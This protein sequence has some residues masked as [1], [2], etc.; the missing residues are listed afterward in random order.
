MTSGRARAVATALLA[1]AA[2]VSMLP[3]PAPAEAVVSDPRLFDGPSADLVGDPQSAMSEDGS[4]GIVYL[5][6][7]EGRAHVFAAKFEDGEWGPSQRVD[8]GQSFDSSWPRIAAGDNGRLLV[9][10]VQEFGID[11]D[12]MFSSTLDP[13]ASGFQSPVPVDFDVNEATSTFPDLA[14]ARGGQAYLIY[15]VITDVNTSNPP[16]YVGL[17]VRLARYSNRLWSAVGSR[18]DR[19]SSVPMRLPTAAIAPQVGIDIQGQAIVGWL[20]PDDDFVDRMWARRVFGGQTGIPVLVS[21]T[22]FNDKPLRGGVSA[23]SLDV[24]GFGQG[25]ASFVQQPGQTGALDAPRL[26]V[27]N[28]PDIFTEGSG[29]FGEAFLADESAR[30]SIGVP[31]VAVDPTGLY[32]SAFSSGAATLLS[33]GDPFSLYGVERVDSG[34]SAT[35]GAPQV[36][37]AG[38]GAGVVA[39]RELRSSGGVVSVQERRADG[40][41]ESTALSAPFGG[42]VGPPALGG[43]GLGDAIVAWS[44]GTGSGRQVAASVVD[45]PPDPF[46]VLVPDVPQ[47][48]ARIPIAWD[49][50][51]NAIG[52]ITY[53]VSVD[54]EP[55]QDGV[56]ATKTMLGPGDI[57]DGRHRI[58]IFA[59]DSAGQETGSLA[60]RLEVDRT[61]PKVKL[62]RRGSVVTLEIDDGPKS[63]SSGLAGGSVSY[64]DGSRGRPGGKST[65]VARER[66]RFDAPGSYRV[67]VVAGDRAGNQVKKRITVKVR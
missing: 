4:G 34:S 57:E 29:E 26:L 58:Q 54:D 21:P 61:A 65:T 35:D 59:V 67:K 2:F 56:E 27:N 20:E 15:N 52:D 25:T 36:D 44:Q 37:L 39:W 6:R 41:L 62:I 14:M 11:S 64:G 22:T 60:G 9:T 28:I 30:G 1:L 16:G 46:F 32:L 33:K 19:N 42:S 23:I 10:W 45:A 3:R 40:V 8:V 5:K 12:R 13:G 17:D 51:S 31:S 48:K 50:S 24:S 53:S 7:L 55:V 63:E 38:T 18:V 47:R 49:P 66:H 43:S